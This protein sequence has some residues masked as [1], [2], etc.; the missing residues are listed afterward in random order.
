MSYGCCL[1][2]HQKVKPSIEPNSI[3]NVPDEIVEKAN[4]GD[5]KSCLELS[6]LLI[7]NENYPKLSEYYLN[8]SI[9]AGFSEAYIY[10]AQILLSGGVI[11]KDGK[12][13]EKF[14]KSA[15]KKNIP[16]A[17]SLLAE[18]YFDTNQPKKG[19]K[20]LTKS[21]KKNNTK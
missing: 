11:E 13:A 10:Y 15:V 5:G 20:I 8:K 19:L 4:E 9:D 21:V 6:K 18:F 2:G 1:F 12:K 3:P 17:P 16:I 14:L 7:D